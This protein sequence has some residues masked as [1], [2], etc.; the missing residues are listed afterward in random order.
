MQLIPKG[1]PSIFEGPM[2]LAEQKSGILNIFEF[3]VVLVETTD[4]SM[5]FDI[6]YA[7]PNPV[8]H[9]NIKTASQK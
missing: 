1:R 4:L 3:L 9:L 6:K 8:M 7:G 5:N 2:P